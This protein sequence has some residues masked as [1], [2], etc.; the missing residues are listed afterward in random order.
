MGKYLKLAV[1]AVTSLIALLVGAQ[2]AAAAE[3]TLSVNQG[4][5]G[6]IV[7]FGGGGWTL[8]PAPVMT[9][10]PA[11]GPALSRTLVVGPDAAGNPRLGGSYTI[12]AGVAVGAAT[13]K[14]EQGSTSQQVAFTVVAF[15]CTGGTGPTVTGPTVTGPTVTGPTVTGPT[16]TGPT[17]TGPTVTGPTNTGPTGGNVCYAVTAGTGPATGSCSLDQI[18]TVS[19]GGGCTDVCTSHGPLWMSQAGNTIALASVN[20][21]QTATGAM[22]TVTVH[23]ERGYT[24]ARGWTLSAKLAGAMTGGASPIPA[25]QVSLAAACDLVAAS[26]ALDQ[27][28]TICKA[29]AGDAAGNGAHAVSGTVSV[30][31]TGATSG[32]GYT[33]TLQLT[34][35]GL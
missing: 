14:V 10:T 32:A 29:N 21:G 15:P 6:T 24:P 20:V 30:V 35:T 25:S 1:I 23:E 18:I 12:P 11:S 19:T 3:I 13:I 9:F 26:G 16:V 28:V 31:T 8:S 22:N 34:L 2:V 17:V 7:F 4:C 5:T 33:G 27:S